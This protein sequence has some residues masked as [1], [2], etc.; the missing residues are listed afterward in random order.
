VELDALADAA[1]QGSVRSGRFSSREQAR[2]TR[3][4]SARTRGGL[5]VRCK[6]FEQ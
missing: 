5:E 6:A 4:K 3:S 2:K 1:S